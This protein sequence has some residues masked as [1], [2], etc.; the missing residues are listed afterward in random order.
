M[1][2]RG[3]LSSRSSVWATRGG[4]PY[5]SCP[6]QIFAVSIGAWRPCHSPVG[7]GSCALPAIARPGVSRSGGSIRS[8][9]T[10]SVRA[11]HSYKPSCGQSATRLRGLWRSA[12]PAEPRSSQVLV[13]Y[14]PSR[15]SFGR[16]L[17][18]SFSQ[19][20][21]EIRHLPHHRKRLQGG[22]ALLEIFGPELAQAVPIRGLL[23]CRVNSEDVNID[24]LKIC[25]QLVLLNLPQHRPD[26]NLQSSIE[27]DRTGI[28]H[29]R[30]EHED[31]APARNW[32]EN[33]GR[34][35]K[36]PQ[37]IRAGRRCG[38]ARAPFLPSRDEL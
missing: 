13:R 30:K 32:A 6:P 27:I 4:C 20:I 11:R 22:T 36:Y 16:V 25:D 33:M 3:F 28:A 23:F 8:V 29:V 17:P 14:G 9:R 15:T 21:R 1:A 24:A 5:R 37:D 12:S 7:A 38:K 26:R 18:N 10:E 2:S 31:I 19:S 34:D 35:D